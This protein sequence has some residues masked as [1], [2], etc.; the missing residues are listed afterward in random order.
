MADKIRIFVGNLSYATTDA[1]LA[2]HFASVGEVVAADILKDSTGHSRGFAFVQIKD[3]ADAVRAI[4]KLDGSELDGRQLKVQEAHA[5]P[6]RAPGPN[7]K[8]SSRH[9]ADRN[10]RSVRY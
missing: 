9:R 8:K 1:V 7:D 6:H 4:E 2:E 3:D 5:A 10:R